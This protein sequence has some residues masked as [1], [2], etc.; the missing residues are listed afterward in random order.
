MIWAAPKGSAASLSVVFSKELR[1]KVASAESFDP[2]SRGIPLDDPSH[3][4]ICL[5][6]QRES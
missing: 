5:Y 6:E 2:D 1:A 3:G 4:S